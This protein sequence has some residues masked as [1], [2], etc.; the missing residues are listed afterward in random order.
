MVVGQ[1]DGVAGEPVRVG[2]VGARPDKQAGRAETVKEAL[3][4]GAGVGG[5]VN[6]ASELVAGYFLTVLAG[7]LVQLGWGGEAL[8]GV[9]AVDAV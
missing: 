7:G 2:G 6:G 5:G 3:F 1:R 8:V 4:A 9:V